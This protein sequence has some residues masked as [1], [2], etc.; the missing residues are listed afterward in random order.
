MK[1]CWLRQCAG[2]DGWDEKHGM[3]LM[4]SSRTQSAGDFHNRASFHP[5]WLLIDLEFALILLIC[6][7]GAPFNR[8]PPT[9]RPITD[10]RNLPRA[11][12][13]HLMVPGLDTCSVPQGHFR[14]PK[15]FP[16]CSLLVQE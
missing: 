16:A 2:N 7:A 6:P 9:P 13:L 8:H 11:L 12:V 5:F 14:F 10:M 1:G 15:L 4:G 3:G